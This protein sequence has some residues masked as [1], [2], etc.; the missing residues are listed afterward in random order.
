MLTPL[1]HGY[2]KKKKLF[3]IHTLHSA[4]SK[5]RF[6]LFENF[7]LNYLCTCHL[8]SPDI[9]IRVELIKL[10]TRFKLTISVFIL[11]KLLYMIL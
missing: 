7:E 9:F 2:S 5:E 10:F 11:K 4:A 8:T 3:S 1:L 6:Q